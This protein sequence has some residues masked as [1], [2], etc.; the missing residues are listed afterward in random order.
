MSESL[1]AASPDGTATIPAFASLT[2]PDGG[3]LAPGEDGSTLTLRPQAAPSIETIFAFQTDPEGIV[4][5]A[6]PETSRYVILSGGHLALAEVDAA[7]AAPFVL[8]R[9]GDAA[10]L[11]LA[12]GEPIAF[13]SGAELV[14]VADGA[15]VEFRLVDATE[16]V[17]AVI[18]A[19]SCCGV[20]HAPRP[21]DGAAAPNWNEIGHQRI[22]GMAIA[23]L[24]TVT[25]VVDR[26][27]AE[28]LFRMFGGFGSP[29]WNRFVQR[30]NDGL[31]DA[32]NKF[33]YNC[34]LWLCH[35]YD[36]Q[37][38]LALSN[39]PMATALEQC[40]YYAAKARDE[41]RAGRCDDAA[42]FLGIALHYLTD[43][44]QP[45]HAANFG[46][47]YSREWGVHPQ[48]HR[49]STFE[50]ASDPRILRNPGP[51]PIVLAKPTTLEELTHNTAVTARRIFNNPMRGI[52]L[53][54]WEQPDWNK[55]RD[56][57]VDRLLAEAIPRAVKSAASFLALWTEPTA[58]RRA[59][60]HVLRC[61]ADPNLVIDL[62]G[63]S[64]VDGAKIQLWP[65][66][67]SDAQKWSFFR[68]VSPPDDAFS[69]FCSAVSSIR[70]A[71]ID[72]GQNDR[73]VKQQRQPRPSQG[74]ML[75][76]V[77]SGHVQILSLLD[78]NTA[79]GAENG[80]VRQGTQLVRQRRD[81]AARHQ[82]WIVEQL[83][84]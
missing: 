47:M 77:D 78:S 2:S 83:P 48:D 79:L 35:F 52:L 37:D 24:R 49:H 4:R 63:G 76:A 23:R 56:A 54:M 29:G 67:S 3:F 8:E 57:D 62:D 5:L 51:D 11:R 7:V 14:P 38:G 6:V 17:T 16:F 73:A 34:G 25:D 84:D 68:T 32:D 80:V 82:R 36:P 41:Y 30:V 45:M 64:Q 65:R 74:F 61:A 60:N 81:R 72:V 55:W 15:A 71:V 46:N 66:N 20:P 12:T 33:P 70:T 53:W 9:A 19:H 21:A 39:P 18:D 27:R 58:F 42:Y 1:T 75:S 26:G 13:T 40:T 50:E 69:Y 31:Y 44:T 28:N 59:P 43:L 10:H 22:V